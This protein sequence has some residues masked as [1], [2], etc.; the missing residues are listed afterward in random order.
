MIDTPQTWHYGLVSELWAEFNIDAPELPFYEEKIKRFGQ[1]ALDLACGTG[2][3]LLPLLN[4]G[5]DIDG[6]D[7]SDDML[8]RCRTKANKSGLHVDLFRQAMHAIDLPRKYRTIYICGSFGLAGSRHLDMETLARCYHHLQPGGALVFN[9]DVEYAFPEAW[10][11]WLRE[12]RNSL[13]ET[14]PSEGDRR[15]ASDGSDYVSRTRMLAIDPLE[16]S[17]ERQIWVEKYRDGQKLREEIYTLWGNYYFMNELKL[18]LEKSGF[19]QIRVTGGYSNDEP[20]ADR[21]DLVYIAT[22]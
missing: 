3:L 2:R 7:I 15:T 20:T 19:H 6:C 11:L 10:P 4:K 21:E 14:W 8:A 17:Y 16:Q 12:N 13:P 1:P 18:M 9:K 22:K 5:I